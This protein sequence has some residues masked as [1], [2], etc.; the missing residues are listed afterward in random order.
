MEIILT[1][2]SQILEQLQKQPHRETTTGNLKY[3]CILD[4]EISLGQKLALKYAETYSKK[5]KREK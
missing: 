3:Q 5:V 2:I 4:M 1:Y